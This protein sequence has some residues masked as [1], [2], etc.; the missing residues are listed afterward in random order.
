M[1]GALKRPKVSY[2]AMSAEEDDHELVK[3]C[4]AVR[5]FDPQ[6]WLDGLDKATF[7]EYHNNVLNM[8]HQERLV[9][10]T[11]DTVHQYKML[12]ETH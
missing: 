9:L 3:E 4:F 5:A 11:L 10:K 2:H 6:Q 7:T 12:K 1:G 8:Q